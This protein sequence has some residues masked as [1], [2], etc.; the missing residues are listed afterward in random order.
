MGERAKP[1]ERYRALTSALIAR[2]ETGAPV[3]EWPL[4]SLDERDNLGENYRTVAQVMTKDLF[5]V[6]PDDVVDLAA[7]LMEW[8]HIRYVPVEDEQGRL[9]GLLSHRS[10]LRPLV[11]GLQGDATTVAVRDVMRTDLVTVSPETTTVEAIDRMR[12]NKVGCLPVVKD[13]RLVGIVTEHD[14]IELSAVLL[15]RWLRAT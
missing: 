3:H 14:F 1:A 7:S 10:L 9:V 6:R 2:Q 11:R 12:R 8:Q 15:D 5:T 13:G 4:A